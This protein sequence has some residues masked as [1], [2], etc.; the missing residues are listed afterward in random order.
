MKKRAI[1]PIDIQRYLGGMKYPATRR[2]LVDHAQFK[3][4]DEGIIS[5]LK[6]LPNRDIYSPADLSHVMA[7]LLAGKSGELD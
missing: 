1:T 5:L 7:V 3:G 2:F 6:K 4:A